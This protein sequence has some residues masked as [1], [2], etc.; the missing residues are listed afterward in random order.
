M[1]IF[2]LIAFFIGKTLNKFNI[3]KI[4]DTFTPDKERSEIQQKQDAV[5][6]LK[7]EIAKSGALKI[8]P[9]ENG[10]VEVTL[11]LIQ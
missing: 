2:G 11:T 8:T 1:L 3:I 7:D 6:L 9:L 5:M 10:K 4:S